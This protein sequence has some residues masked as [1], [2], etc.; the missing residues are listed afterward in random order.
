MRRVTVVGELTIDNGAL[1][2]TW[3]LRRKLVAERHAAQIDAMY[4]ATTSTAT[5]LVLW[6]A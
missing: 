3:K 6:V 5:I 4:A 1:T 2:P